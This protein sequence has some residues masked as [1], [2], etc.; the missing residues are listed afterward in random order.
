MFGYR[1]EGEG[2][3][4]GAE[5]K[6]D[7]EALLKDNMQMRWKGM[8]WADCHVAWSKDG[9]KKTICDLQ[10]ALI[11]IIKDTKGRELCDKPPTKV[12]K[13]KEAPALG[14]MTHKAKELADKRKAMEHDFD[15]NARKRWKA[16]DRE[17]HTSTIV[18]RW[19]PEASKVV[20]EEEDR[21]VHTV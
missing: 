14:T 11:K 15:M 4:E 8:G 1:G 16:Q 19:A 12:P 2:R 13:R 18:Y 20:R 6:K 10:R 9:K 3:G 17:E 21:G 7:K 5:V